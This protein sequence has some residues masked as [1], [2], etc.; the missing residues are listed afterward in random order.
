MDGIVC[1][2]VTGGVVQNVVSNIR[3]VRVL[4]VDYDNEQTGEESPE[5]RKS[6]FCIYDPEYV[7]ATLIGKEEE[8]EPQDK[9]EED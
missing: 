3:N 1:I 9:T 7:E 6:S 5:D 8:L 4:V 2:Y